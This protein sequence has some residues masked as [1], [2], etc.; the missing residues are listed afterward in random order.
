[1]P[2]T[3]DCEYCDC[4]GYPY[5]WNWEIDQDTGEELQL[6]CLCAGDPPVKEYKD[7]PEFP[8][9]KQLCIEKILDFVYTNRDITE[10]SYKS[11]RNT[12]HEGPL[13][14]VI[15]VRET[16]QQNNKAKC[17][18]LSDFREQITQMEHFDS[19]P[20]KIQFELLNSVPLVPTYLR[21]RH[22]CFTCT[23]T[24][25]DPMETCNYCFIVKE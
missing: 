14:S 16:H 23:L 3:H 11:K 13:A 9:L 25:Y 10:E 22:P 5:C 6:S 8:T 2:K 1:M 24:W 19:L 15:S 21:D 4:V 18:D 12:G 20:W 17:P 7:E